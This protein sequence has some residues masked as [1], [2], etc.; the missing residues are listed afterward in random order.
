M[1]QRPRKKM[2][3]APEI[4]AHGRQRGSYS[5]LQPSR[6]LPSPESSSVSSVLLAND[7]LKLGTRS[8]SIAKPQVPPKLAC[9]Q[10]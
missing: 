4:E 9:S 6:E 7:V 2:R 3:G 10:R 1:M 8:L 5:K